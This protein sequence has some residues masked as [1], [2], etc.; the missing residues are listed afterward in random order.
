MK[1]K[2]LGRA[3]ASLSVSIVLA[4]L[5][6]PSAAAATADD[7]TEWG[8]IVLAGVAFVV[9]AGSV[10]IAS[11]LGHRLEPGLGHRDTPDGH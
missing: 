3:L 8:L 2:K 11:I 9:F 5:V 1:R 7:E 6:V 10:A 4:A